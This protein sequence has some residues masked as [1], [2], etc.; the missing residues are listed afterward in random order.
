MRGF[1]QKAGCGSQGN[2]LTVMNTIRFMAEDLDLFSAASNDKN[3]LHLSEEYARLTPYGNRVVFGVLNA[4]TALAA[5]PDRPGRVLSSIE[6]EFFDIAL[7]GVNYAVEIHEDDEAHGTLRVMDGVRPILEAVLSFSRGAVVSWHSGSW[8]HHRSEPADLSLADLQIGRKANGQY[9]PDEQAFESLYSRLF[10]KSWFGRRHVAALLWASYLIGMEIPGRRALFSRLRIDFESSCLVIAPFMYEA[11]TEAVSPLGE[12]NIEA[13]LSSAGSVWATVNLSAYVREDVPPITLSSVEELVGR[14]DSLSGKVALVTGGSRGLGCA[15]VHALTLHGCT[16]IL[17][18]VRNRN[19][20]EQ[21]RDSVS[22]APGKVVLEPGNAGDLHWCKEL[23]ERIFEQFGPLDFLICNASLP[24]LPLWLD[25][26]SAIRIN[27]F[28]QASV[29]LAT[30]PMIAFL[31]H[32]AARKGWNVLVSSVAATQPHPHFPHYTT[33]KCATEAIL[34]SAATEYRDVSS[35]IVRPARMLTD[36]TNTPLGRRGAIRPERVAS[37]IVNRLRKEP[38]RGKVEILEG[39]TG[40]D[41]P[42]SDHGHTE[43]IR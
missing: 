10:S 29:A 6:L 3:P 33:A 27:E 1:V 14:G 31:S 18:F 35:L 19:L 11:H 32:L 2:S 39:F 34:R 36:L 30:S 15:M 16:T 28:L 37:A 41:T 21:V 22:G 38:C 24:L 25:A 12:V 20:A 17:N 42:V 26:P 13:S 9:A 7:L 40:A 4:L 8:P 23:S 43:G 5:V